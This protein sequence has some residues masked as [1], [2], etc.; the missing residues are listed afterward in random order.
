MSVNIPFYRPNFPPWSTVVGD[1]Q[2]AYEA[3]MLAPGKYTK[4]FEQEV[5]HLLQVKHA[6]AF[7]NC[8][9]AMMCLLGYLKAKTGRNTVIVPSFTFSATWQAADWNGMKTIVVDSDDEGLISVPHLKAA[10]TEHAP[11][12]AC[13]MAVHMFGNPAHVGELA[14]LSLEYDVPVCFDAAHGFCTYT[15]TGSFL[16][17][18]GLAEVFSIGTT[19]P[20]AAGEG[21]VLTTEDDELADAMYRASMHGHKAGELDVELK[22]LNGRIQEIN[23]IIAYYGLE[24]IQKNMWQ[25]AQLATVYNTA[26]PLTGLTNAT[27]VTV[28]PAIAPKAAGMPSYKDYTLFIRQESLVT[29]KAVDPH[30]YRESFI[31]A[32][33]KRGVHTKR[34]YYPDIAN[35]TVVLADPNVDKTSYNDGNGCYLSRGCVSIPFY[36]SLTA[37]DQQYVIDSIRAVLVELDD[38]GNGHGV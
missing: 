31:A 9:D 36:N 32:L 34:Y 30:K 25:R 15:N 2:E 27:R 24:D 20:I 11:D 28:R 7:S 8:A 35:L 4:R 10:L 29:G 16:G 14:A 23:S 33:E 26:F 38:T 22:S 17:H 6:I 21:G 3:G 13:V 18:S 37:Y 5:R 19:K 12:I 1:I